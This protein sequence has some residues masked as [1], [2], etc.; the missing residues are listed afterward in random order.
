MRGQQS[1]RE[2]RPRPLFR[3]HES[4]QT[5][6]LQV[7][8]SP[9]THTLSLSLLMIFFLFCVH[10]YL[11][12]DTVFPCVGPACVEITAADCSPSPPF[13]SIPLPSPL[14]FPSL[15]PSLSLSTM[16]DNDTRRV[17]QVSSAHGRRHDRMGHRDFQRPRLPPHCTSSSSRVPRTPP[18]FY[19]ISPSSS[20]TLNS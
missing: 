14:S 15:Y 10:I 8:P 12:L 18:L 9:H 5:P 6:R 17:V 7:P 11:R 2:P 19:N 4:P 16:Q 1:A 3:P 20:K 13:L